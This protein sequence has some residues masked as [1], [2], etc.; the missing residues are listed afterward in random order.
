[1]LG[2]YTILSDA[3][4]VYSRA[5]G[6]L[7]DEELLEHADAL[8]NDPR[9]DPSFSQLADSREMTDLAVS[10]QGVRTLATRNPFGK[11][12]KRALVAPSLVAFG[13]ARM[14]ELVSHRSEDDIKVVKSMAE[15]KAW[16]GDRAPSNWEELEKL[17]PDRVFGVS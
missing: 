3:R 13:M 9:F 11:G 7:T 5:W 12:A 10:P 16:L 4:F 2:S 8:R 14:F 1:M 15:A 6:I 17:K